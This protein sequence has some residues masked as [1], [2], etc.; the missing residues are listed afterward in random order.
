MSDNNVIDLPLVDNKGRRHWHHPDRRNMTECGLS[1]DE[2]SFIL[3]PDAKGIC[4]NCLGVAMERS[5][6]RV[7][8]KVLDAATVWAENIEDLD[9]Q[10]ALHR[11]VTYYWDW[12]NYEG[13]DE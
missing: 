3:D 10:I 6:L 1:F 7:L 9:S 12:M 4:W 11:A 13:E 8:K 5:E 2:Y